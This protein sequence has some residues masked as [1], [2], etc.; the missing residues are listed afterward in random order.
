MWPFTN[1]NMDNQNQP[2]PVSDPNAPQPTVVET[3][4]VAPLE[5]PVLTPEGGQ[6]DAPVAPTEV[7]APEA[8]VAPEAPTEEKKI[9]NEPVITVDPAA[10]NAPSPA[11]ETLPYYPVADNQHH[12]DSDPSFNCVPCKGDGLLP[13]G[14]TCTA[15]GGTGKA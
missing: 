4:P 14:Q 11:E 9:D 13:S 3:P 2:L 7:P 15:C 10:E 8:P 5:S 6:V 12:V 1:N